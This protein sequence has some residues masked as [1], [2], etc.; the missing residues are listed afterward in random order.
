MDFFFFL[1][2]SNGSVLFYDFHVIVT[3]L[4]SH[5]RNH[6]ACKTYTVWTFIE[7]VCSPI[8][9]RWE[10]HQ[11]GLVLEDILKIKNGKEKLFWREDF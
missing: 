3:E 9:K 6:M 4:N 11:R 1:V 5:D 7:K 8:S 10:K 2:S